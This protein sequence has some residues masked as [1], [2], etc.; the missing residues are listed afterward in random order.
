MPTARRDFT[1]HEDQLAEALAQLTPDVERHRRGRGPKRERCL[2][3][4][5]Q[6]ILQPS[7]QCVPTDVDGDGERGRCCV[8]QNRQSN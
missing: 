8:N 1:I 5:D 6:D 4:W 2:S 7:S 3:Y